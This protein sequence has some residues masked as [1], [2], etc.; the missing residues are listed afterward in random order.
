VALTKSWLSDASPASDALDAADGSAT[1]DFN[2]G[3][4]AEWCKHKA[5]GAFLAVT[6][7]NLDEAA[8]GYV[9]TGPARTGATDGTGGEPVGP[10]QKITLVFEGGT[11]P[12]TEFSTFGDAGA[13]HAWG[14]RFE[15]SP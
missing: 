1:R 8:D 11:R 5:P 10:G 13:A 15:K 7:T 14:L 9:S 3:D 4:A 2:D 12:Y 6:L